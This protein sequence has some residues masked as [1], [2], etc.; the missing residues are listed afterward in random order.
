MWIGLTIGPFFQLLTSINPRS[1]VGYL[2]HVIPCLLFFSSCSLYFYH[3]SCIRYEKSTNSMLQKQMLF[4]FLAVVNT[5]LWF[6]IVFSSALNDAPTQEGHKPD[7]TYSLI[8]STSV[9]YVWLLIIVFSIYQWV[10]VYSLMENRNWM[11]GILI[12]WIITLVVR[13]VMDILDLMLF[14][15]NTQ[16]SNITS[17]INIYTY[18]F[19]DVI[20]GF[21]FILWKESEKLKLEVSLRERRSVPNVDVD[22]HNSL[23]YWIPQEELTF[24]ETDLIGYGA[25]GVVYR[26]MWNE[27]TEVAIKK[28]KIPI[29]FLD[30]GILEEFMREIITLSQ[31]LH[32]NIVQYLGASKSNLGDI[33]LITEFINGGSLSS[34]LIIQPHLSDPTIRHVLSCIVAGMCYLHSRKPPIIH[35]DL[36]PQNLLVVGD[37]VSVKIA[38]FGSSKLFV[39]E[40]MITCGSTG[41]LE[42][43]AP[44]LLYQRNVSPKSDVYSVGVILWQL[45]TGLIP[46]PE[47]KEDQT[48]V[49]KKDLIKSEPKLVSYLNGVSVD[50]VFEKLIRDCLNDNPKMRPSFE[51][52]SQQLKETVEYV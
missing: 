45:V 15:S 7:I 9:I 10:K 42:Y 24:N 13:I 22:L 32:P 28:Y 21:C 50:P 5:C 27:T 8:A 35:R 11:F 43:M 18:L 30:P 39:N 38:D 19:S 49:E 44:E 52:I 33:F 17:Q 2:L 14:Q 41:T 4:R 34:K 25:V 47:L 12:I 36:K 3:W 46:Y 37:F 48:D 29:A 6:I 16:I 23:K 51:N 20:G 26:A 31:L 40:D 1:N